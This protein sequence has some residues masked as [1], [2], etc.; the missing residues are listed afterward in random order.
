VLAGFEVPDAARTA[1]EAF[2]GGLGYKYEVEEGNEA[3]RRFLAS[4]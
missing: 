1:F 2:L 4:S 3:Y